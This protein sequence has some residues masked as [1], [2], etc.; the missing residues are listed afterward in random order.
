VNRNVGDFLG[1]CGKKKPIYFSQARKAIGKSRHNLQ[2]YIY[3]ARPARSVTYMVRITNSDK[4]T[5]STNASNTKS[6]K[7]IHMCPV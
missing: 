2:W 4:P 5:L 6:Q 3:S 1:F 7:S